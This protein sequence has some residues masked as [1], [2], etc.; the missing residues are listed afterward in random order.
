MKQISHDQLKPT[1]IHFI[2]AAVALAALVSC[3]GVAAPPA[4]QD[5]ASRGPVPLI[6]IEDVPSVYAI[7]N[8]ARQAGLNYIL[9]PRVPGAGFG[10]GGLVDMPSINVR[11]TNLTVMAALGRL[12]NA[13]N[14]TMVTNPAT[15]VMRIAPR[16]HDVKPVPASQVGANTNAAIPLMVMDDVQLT[17]AIQALATEA[18]LSVSLD[19]ELSAPAFD[20]GTISIRW[21][22]ITARQAL[23]ALLDNYDLVLIEEPGAASARITLKSRGEIDTRP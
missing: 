1:P 2:R 19:P 22:N 20:Q 8:L 5:A 10:P 16:N 4:I 14:L 13:L 21:E 7:K 23:A 3:A 9:D 18:R 11:W 17:Q 12:L 15:T 6:V